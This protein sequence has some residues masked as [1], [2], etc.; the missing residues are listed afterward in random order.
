MGCGISVL[1]CWTLAVALM[2]GIQVSKCP[3]WF[4]FMLDNVKSQRGISNLWMSIRWDFTISG[5]PWDFPRI[6]KLKTV[7]ASPDVSELLQQFFPWRNVLR[8]ENWNN[9]G[10]QAG[11]QAPSSGLARNHS[12]ILDW[13]M[14]V[15]KVF[16]KLFNL[17]LLDVFLQMRILLHE[18]WRE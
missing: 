5:I 9:C 2:N 15:S 7:G 18:L 13:G 1:G 6:V 12:F 4:W 17:C 14:I 8:F 16:R 10:I 11:E 3:F